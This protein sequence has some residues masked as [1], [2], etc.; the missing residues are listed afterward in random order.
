[1]TMSSFPSDSAFKVSAD[2]AR[3]RIAAAYSSEVVSKHNNTLRN[4]DAWRRNLQSW[5]DEL[6]DVIFAMGDD[7]SLEA[8]EESIRRLTDISK[9]M[10]TVLS[11]MR[12]SSSPTDD[13]AGSPARSGEDNVVSDDVSESHVD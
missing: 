1:M 12:D 5:N 3:Q 6:D 13:S 4:I 2:Q 7:Y 11:S 8:Q 10:D 9:R